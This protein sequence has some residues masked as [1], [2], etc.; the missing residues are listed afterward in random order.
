MQNSNYKNDYENNQFVSTRFIIE[1]S[2][3]FTE[4]IALALPI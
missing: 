3:M 1:Y 2:I 4:R